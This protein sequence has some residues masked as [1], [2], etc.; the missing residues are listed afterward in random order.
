MTLK[1]K[2]NI[3]NSFNDLFNFDSKEDELALKEQLLIMKFLGELDEAMEESKMKKKSLA[4]EIGTSAAY[5]TQ[6]FTGNRKPNFSIITKMADSL[7]VE[8]EVTTKSKMQKQNR[9]PRSDGEGFWIYRPFKGS[10]D[11]S[12]DEL[13]DYSLLE[14]EKEPLAS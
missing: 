12:E 11:K 6:L 4:Q 2:E 7:G 5:I 13:Y 10:K 8:F 9:T 1:T 3:Q 14:A